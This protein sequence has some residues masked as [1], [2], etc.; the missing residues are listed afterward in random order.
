MRFEVREIDAVKFDGEDWQ[1]N[2]SRPIGAFKTNATDHKRAF[3]Y[4]LHKMGIVCKRGR[5][6][7]KFDGDTYEVKDRR[8]GK[9]LYAAI[10]VSSI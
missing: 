9:P 1:W 8:T 10:P 5:M 4:A 6:A 2:T 7:V 3:L